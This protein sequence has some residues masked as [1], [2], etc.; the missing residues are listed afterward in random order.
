MYSVLLH[1]AL[2]I[3]VA[4]LCSI[5]RHIFKTGVSQRISN[6]ILQQQQQQE[7]T[8]TTQQRESTQRQPSLFGVDWL[9]IKRPFRGAARFPRYLPVNFKH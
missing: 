5:G 2:L 9:G 3:N 7:T 8:A 4:R 1:I 6:D